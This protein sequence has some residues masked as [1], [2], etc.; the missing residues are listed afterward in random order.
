MRLAGGDTAAPALV[1]FPALVAKSGPGQFA[2]FAGTLRG[3]RE[4]VALPEPGFLPGEPL[5]ARWEAA[6]EAQTEA[7]RR[8]AGGA[9]VALLGYSSGG[10]IAQAVAARLDET[11]ETPAALILLDTYLQAETSGALATALTD[12]LFTRHGSDADTDTRSLTAM[13]AY[14]RV[15]EDWTPTGTDAPTLFLRAADALPGTQPDAK[16]S[17]A[18]EAT[19][20]ET[21]GDHF[22][23]LEEHAGTTARAVHSWLAELSQRTVPLTSSRSEHND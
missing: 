17:W 5:P 14:F 19:L 3:L 22:S 10:W 15:F 21:A 16:P 9:P 8:F 2:R 18:P 7:V 20:Q 11:G 13:G 1:C 12:G 23:M 6:V 4:V